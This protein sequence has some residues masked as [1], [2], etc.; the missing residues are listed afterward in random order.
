MLS[1]PQV[2][3]RGSAVFAPVALL[4]SPSG[5]LLGSKYGWKSIND[6]TTALQKDL[7]H[8]ENVE[9]AH[10]LLQRVIMCD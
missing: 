3:S 6:G 1:V 9:I 8:D 4:F 10:P 2:V 7:H 5:Y